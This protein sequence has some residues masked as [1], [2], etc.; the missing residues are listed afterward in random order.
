MSVVGHAVV[1]DT[2][3]SPLAGLHHFYFANLVQLGI[4]QGRA[5][6]SLKYFKEFGVQLRRKPNSQGRGLKYFWPNLALP[7]L[8]P[9]ALLCT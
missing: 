1:Q 4:L 2:C 8:P 3:G 7:C 5:Q 9:V 6:L